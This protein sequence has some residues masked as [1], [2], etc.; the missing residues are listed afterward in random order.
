MDCLQV[1]CFCVRAKFLA[2]AKTRYKQ[3]GIAQLSTLNY[4]VVSVYE[5]LLYTHI[6]VDIGL[7]PKR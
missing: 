3:D 5:K 1:Y 4:T 2:S 7:P 6:V